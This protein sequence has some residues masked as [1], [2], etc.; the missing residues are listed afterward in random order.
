M[1]DDEKFIFCSYLLTRTSHLSPL[2]WVND[3][4]G[5]SAVSELKADFVCEFS[6]TQKNF[7]FS[8]VFL[9][10]AMSHGT[11]IFHQ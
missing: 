3:I 9:K 4:V 8:A 5:A 7:N 2:S 10:N 6:E 11:I 1:K